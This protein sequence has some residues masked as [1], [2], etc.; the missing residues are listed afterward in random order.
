MNVR[1]KELAWSIG[2]AGKN[3]RGQIDTDWN[4]IEKFA[5]LIVKECTNMLPPDSIRDEN[6]VHMFYVIRKHFGVSE[7]GR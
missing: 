1:I 2:I 4:Q 6:G 5:E 7:I 3:L